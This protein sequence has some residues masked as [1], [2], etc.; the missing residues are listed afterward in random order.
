MKKFAFFLPQFH[1]IQEN[2]EWWGEGFTEWT[3]VRKAVPLYEG[4]VQPKHPLN[5]NYYDLLDRKTVEWQTDLMH[6]YHVDG[7]IYYHYYFKGKKLLEKP[8]ENLLRWTDIDQPFFFCWANHSWFRSSQ[9]SK[10]LLIEQ[11][12]GDEKDWEEHFN[13]LLPF[14]KDPRYEKKDNK[15]LFL[16]FWSDFAEKKQI[17]SY[18]EKRCRE[19]GF[20]GIYLIETFMFGREWP[21]DLYEFKANVAT[22]TERIL[23]REPT[24]SEKIYKKGLKDTF[25]NWQKKENSENI[26]ENR[27]CF[28]DI[29]D[30]DVLYDVIDRIEPKTSEYIHTIFFGWDNTPRHGPWGRVKTPPSKACFMQAMDALKNDEY[31]F[32]NAWN[33][34]AEGMMLEPTEENGYK[35][36]EWIREW[37]EKN[38]YKDS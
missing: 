3:N 12:Y 33:E 2:N 5:N 26:K 9:G 32:I 4:H 31:V 24:V 19:N 7:L 37:K 16:I 11:K 1:E 18:F 27:E 15:P 35:Y 8:A 6:T 34:W 38:E 28:A 23:L 22:Q 13:Y 30:S 29:I 14:F 36:L 21:E 17:F 10:Q 20:N 25:C